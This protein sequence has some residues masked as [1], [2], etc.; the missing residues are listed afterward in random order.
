MPE[1]V[2]LNTP[3]NQLHIH[4]IARLGQHSSGKLAQALA[5]T[6]A[7]TA[8]HEVTVED[9]LGYLPMRYE[10]RSNLAR[11]RNLKDGRD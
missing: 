2:T 8:A 3:V 6:T 10:D 9:L 7:A 1:S 4:H 5:G 11:I